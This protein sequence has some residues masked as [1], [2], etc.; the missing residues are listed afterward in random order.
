MNPT[1]Y[2]TEYCIVLVTAADQQEAEHLAHTIIGEQLAAC[3]SIVP[4]TSVYTWQN[5]VHQNPEWQLLIKTRMDIYSA[6]AKRVQQLHRFEVPEIIA[7]PIVAGS[8]SYLSWIGQQVRNL[9]D[10]QA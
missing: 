6:L 2:C 1:E 3:V 5:Q 9:P 4:I 7:L 8:S 10:P